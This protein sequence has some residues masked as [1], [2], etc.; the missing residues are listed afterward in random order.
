M[1][2]VSKAAICL[3]FGAPFARCPPFAPSFVGGVTHF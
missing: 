1:I 2:P 3:T